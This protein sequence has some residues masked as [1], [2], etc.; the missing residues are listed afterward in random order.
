MK[1]KLLNAV[2][3]LYETNFRLL[4]WNAAGE[5]FND[6]HKSITEQYYE[7]LAGVIDE[8]SEIMGIFDIFPPNYVEVLDIIKEAETRF[9]IVESGKLYSRADIIKLTNIMFEDIRTLLVSVLEDYTFEDPINAGVKSKLEDIL[10]RFTFE[11]Q[12]INKR[13]GTI[14]GTIEDIE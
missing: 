2:L 11:Q 6:A 7:M 8:V 10:Y 1:F 13:R 14:P 4:H 9:I 3:R 5:E 12:Y